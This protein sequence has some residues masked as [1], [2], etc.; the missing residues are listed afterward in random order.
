[1]RKFTLILASLFLCLGTQ[2]QTF[3]TPTEGGLYRIKGSHSTNP[4]LTATV[5]SGGIDV[6][7]DVAGAGVYEV[8]KVGGKL[9]LKVYGQ[10]LYVG[11]SNGQ[12]TLVSDA[13]ATALEDAGDK[14]TYIKNGGRYLYNNQ[15]DYTREA[16]NLTATGNAEHPKWGFVEYFVTP[17]TGKFYTI[18]GEG[19]LPWVTANVSSGG[20]V[21]VSKNEADA[22]VFLKT[23][24]GLL[25]VAT[26]KY[27]G[28]TGG[29]YTYS[30]TELSIDLRNNGD[31]L[32]N[33]SNKYA[34]VS[35]GNYMFNNNTDGIVHESNQALNLARLWAFT[36]VECSISGE[37]TETNPFRIYN[38][39]QLV[40]FR[41]SV[42]AGETK[43]SAPGVHVA[44]GADIN[45]TGINWVG[46]G[47]ATA[48]HGFMG[49][50]DG[51]GYKIKN[52][53]I[54]NPGLVGG[55]AYAGFFSVTEGEE[56]NQNSIKNLTIENVT[57][58]TTG[59]IVAAAIAYPYY[60]I[61][62]NVTV[63]GN[64]AIQ[65]GD[66]TAGALA[67]TRRCVNASNITVDGS[68]GTITGAT[69]VG[70][71]IS[72]LQLNGGLVADYSNFNVSGVTITGTKAVGGITGIIGGQT[73]NGCSVENVTL[74]AKGQVG[75]VAG[76][77]GNASTISEVLY[78]NVTGAD[79]IIGAGYDTG[80]AVEAK[81]GDTYYCTFDA[82][83]A[84][85]GTEDVELLIEKSITLSDNEAYT[86]TKGA[87][88]VSVEYTRNLIAGIWNPV[89]IPFE[90][91]VSAEEFEVAKFTSAEGSTV[92]LTKLEAEEGDICLEA[93]KA[94][95]IRPVGDNTTL[96]IGVWG[97]IYHNEEVVQDLGD[98]FSVK[99]NY[100]KLTGADLAG[101]ER[102]V[103]TNGNWGVLKSASTLKPYRLI[104]T[105]PAGVDAASISMR[106]EEEDTTSI[107]TLESMTEATIYDLMGRRV[108][109]MTEGGIYIV[110]G[111]KVIR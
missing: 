6:A 2:A 11:T 14:K 107:E 58:E 83:M 52:L 54:T 43:Y 17:E 32:A 75:I 13:N 26:G 35:G 28:Y 73:L 53:T 8:V 98:G 44:L 64:I 18:K 70:G 105:I 29:K 93:N 39:E 30:D 97:C 88:D 72:D 76:S 50:F 101:N 68:E 25:A 99:G 5:E 77:L 55:Y 33:Y 87:A 103:G 48:D 102:V 15:A 49:N 90:T 36:E 60:T 69:T 109:T 84:A 89:Y 34:I 106:V 40:D 62:E 1:M 63:C 9:N 67:Y 56:G 81:I 96:E 23:A 4:W 65:G 100:S 95:V 10:D 19:E 24:N 42:N 78:D 31:Y 66:Y 92:T 51:N 41:N 7:A 12:I 104:L 111:K 61:V 46:I 82:A 86:Y 59:H 45:M 3:V 80:T 79:A 74:D 20:N 57:I 27:L 108:E 16:G 37:G 71:V 91:P 94:Y 38:A 47:S 22:A 21:V 85:E 110:N